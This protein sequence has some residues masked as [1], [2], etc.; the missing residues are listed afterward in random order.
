MPTPNPPSKTEIAQ[1]LEAREIMPTAQRVDIAA[2]LLA[3]KQHVS[4]EQVMAR[5]RRT[6]LVVSKATVYNTLGLFVARG[7]VRE[8][9]VDS[10]RVFYDSNIDPHYHFYNLDD[11][12]LEDVATVHVP[13][14]QLPAPP[15]GTVTAGVD[16]VIRIRNRT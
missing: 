4:A 12:T 11:G 13:I 3:T 2:L 8:V 15:P 1:M 5:A 14:E 10:A 9:I 7:L 6:G 16:I